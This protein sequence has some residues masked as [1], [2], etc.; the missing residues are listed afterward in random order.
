MQ[1]ERCDRDAQIEWAGAGC[2]AT[3]VALDLPREQLN[4]RVVSRFGLHRHMQSLMGLR[5]SVGFAASKKERTGPSSLPRTE[6]SW[7]RTGKYPSTC[8]LPRLRDGNGVQVGGAFGARSPNSFDRQHLFD[9][10]FLRRQ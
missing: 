6:E 7:G 5:H 1:M 3:A 2:R 4:Q 8:E 9:L 10:F